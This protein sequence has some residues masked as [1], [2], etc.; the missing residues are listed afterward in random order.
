M[1]KVLDLN[2]DG[3]IDFVRSCGNLS[4][5]FSLE[6]QNIL[7]DEFVQ[8]MDKIQPQLKKIKKKREKNI[9]RK[10]MEAEQPG[11]NSC[12]AKQKGKGTESEENND[13]SEAIGK[14]LE[15]ECMAL[16]EA[17]SATLEEKEKRR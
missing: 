17:I 4:L 13:H 16:T 2:N 5:F 14:L 15:R 6:S 9:T 11:M 8:L 12:N 1:T 7:Q 3:K 10:C